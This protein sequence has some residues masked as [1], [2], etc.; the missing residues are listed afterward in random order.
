MIT[1]LGLETHPGLNI[2][3]HFRMDLPPSPTLTQQSITINLPNT[4]YYLRVTPSISP[5]LLER[6]HKVFVTCG[7][8]LHALPLVSGQPIDT[9]NSVYEIRLHPGVNRIEVEIIAALPKGAKPI[10][11]QDYETENIMVYAN[12]MKA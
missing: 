8:R 7:S 3:R 12:L 1:N 6:Q 5:S 9:R 2:S 10:N 11:G 4:H